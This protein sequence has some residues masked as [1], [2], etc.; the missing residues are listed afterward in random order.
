[1]QTRRSV[2]YRR[3]GATA[4]VLA[5]CV[6]APNEAALALDSHGFGLRSIGRRASRVI[7]NGRVELGRNRG[8]PGLR[9]S[10]SGGQASLARRRL[11]G[12]RRASGRDTRGLLSR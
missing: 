6:P 3:A 11:S 8:R 10:A 9:R 5:I 2:S 4:E 1:M 7:A 12:T